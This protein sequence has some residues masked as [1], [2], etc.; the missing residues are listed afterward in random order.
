MIYI[1]ATAVGIVSGLVLATVWLFAALWV[2]LYG[3]MFLSSMRNEGGVGAAG[4]GSG[5]IML[6]AL[7]G[8]AAGFWW[9]LRRANAAIP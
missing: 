8:F 6:A 2:P 5:S 4:V 7:I 3:K 9:T 1:K